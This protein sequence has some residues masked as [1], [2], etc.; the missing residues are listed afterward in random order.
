[1]ALPADIPA[2]CR[3]HSAEHGKPELAR[4]LVS[5][6]FRGKFKLGHDRNT[7]PVE[8]DFTRSYAWR[9]QAEV[10]AAGSHV[11]GKRRLAIS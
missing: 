11:E 2:R 4:R 7:D 3:A 1:M 6:R 10:R 8:H 5:P 9:G